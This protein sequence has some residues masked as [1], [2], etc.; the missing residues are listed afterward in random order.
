MFKSTLLRYNVHT[1][2]CSH[3][4]C[5]TQR[6]PAHVHASVLSP[7]ALQAPGGLIPSTLCRSHTRVSVSPPCLV[8]ASLTAEVVLLGFPLL[9]VV[10]TFHLPLFLWDF[11]S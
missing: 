2:K 10:C 7:E 11:N 5:I 8:C 3:F 4:Q 1:T 9:R 6:A